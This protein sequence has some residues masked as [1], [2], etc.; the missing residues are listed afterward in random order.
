MNEHIKKLREMLSQKEIDAME[1]LTVMASLSGEMLVKRDICLENGEFNK[2][3]KIHYRLAHLYEEL[4]KKIPTEYRELFMTMKY[5][6]R[7]TGNKFWEPS[8]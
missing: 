8:F 6:W 2:A 4:S 5:Y 1:V 7:T 3:R